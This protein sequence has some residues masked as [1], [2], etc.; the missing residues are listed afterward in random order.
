MREFDEE[1]NYINRYVFVFIDRYALC[2]FSTIYIHK[3]VCEMTDYSSW[4]IY[5][6][7]IKEEGL[8]MVEE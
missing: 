6:N 2:V 5:I 3:Y 1:H 4:L 7:T 8:K